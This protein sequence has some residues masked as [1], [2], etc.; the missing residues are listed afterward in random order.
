MMGHAVE[1]P[2]K[3]E[4]P[5]KA[6]SQSYIT[7]PPTDAVVG[8]VGGNWRNPCEHCLPREMVIDSDNLMNV[9]P[10]V[11]E[12]MINY[13]EVLAHRAAC[14]TQ[15]NPRKTIVY[16]VWFNSCSPQ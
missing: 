4:G 7:N 15:G 2:K 14:T 10:Q 11:G 3:K 12:L 13:Q 6:Q 9:I 8:R 16:S 5:T 1:S